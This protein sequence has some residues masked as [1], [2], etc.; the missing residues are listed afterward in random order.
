MLTTFV[1]SFVRNIASWT[2]CYQKHG[3]VRWPLVNIVLG[4]RCLTPSGWPTNRPTKARCGRVMSRQ[5]LS[6]LP[7]R[8]S[9]G[10][11]PIRPPRL[12]GVIATLC[13][14]CGAHRR[15][16]FSSRGLIENKIKQ[17]YDA[18]VVDK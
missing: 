9:A 12:T 18:D 11:E 6:R 4:R 17:R 7:C 1:L 2:C 10:D 5:S 3:F 16:C 13:R 8:T 15:L 14:L